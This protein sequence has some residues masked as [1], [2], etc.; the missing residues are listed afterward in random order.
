MDRRRFLLTS[1]A[2]ALAAPV[3]ADAQRP[4]RV[5]RVGILAEVSPPSDIAGPT[6][7]SGPIREFLTRLRDLGHQHG[8]NILTEVRSAQGKIERFPALAAEL[9]QANVDIIV[10]TSNRGAMAAKEAT[11][12]IPIVMAGASDPVGFGL[13]A[14]LA[15]PGGNV[16]GV[17]LD[18]GPEI[19][20]KRLELLKEM[21]AGL[22]RLAYFIPRLIWLE[23]PGGKA[24]QDAAAKLGVTLVPIVVTNRDELDDAGAM[25]RRARPDGLLVEAYVFVWAERQAVSELALSHRLPTMFGNRDIV[26]AGGLM[27]HS[28]DF[29]TVYRRAAEYVDL[30]LK[31]TKPADLPVEQPTKFDLVINLKTAKALGVTIPASV[32]LRADHVIE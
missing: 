29:N 21:A 13:V 4:T 31:G 20:S 16:T 18:T 9:V 14:T 23:R 7:K 19:A 12:T 10:V 5:R 6:P 2:S 3:V 26:E 22:R 30:I 1:L 28:A 24:V 15:R 27:S 11:A 32:L 17:A 8:D 25:F